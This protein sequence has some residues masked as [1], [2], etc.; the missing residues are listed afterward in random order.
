MDLFF[1]IPV[2]IAVTAAEELPKL[3]ARG[4]AEIG[5]RVARAK[6]I[7]RVATGRGRRDHIRRTVPAR[8]GPRTGGVGAAGRTT[9]QPEAGD[10][11]V[12]AVPSIPD[13]L[14]MANT[15]S[16]SEAPAARAD[17][18]LGSAATLSDSTVPANEGVGDVDAPSASSASGAPDLSGASSGAA[19]PGGAASGAPVPGAAV[20]G[21]PVSGAADS[22]A[23]VP[24]AAASGAPVPTADSLAIPGYDSLAASQVVPRL[25]GLTSEELAA[26]GVYE[27][28]H[29][30]RTTILTRIRQLQGH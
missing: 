24:G 14:S 17:E 1:Y 6:M 19:V 21:A 5:G 13:D 27:A 23:L 20:S 11:A 30:R 12:D 25:A 3:A 22:G 28:A 9:G 18:G 8:G 2:G 4:R 10:R 7:G 29:R 16:S 15:P 26:V